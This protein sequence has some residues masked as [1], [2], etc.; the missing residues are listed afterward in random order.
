[1]NILVLG[2]ADRIPVFAQPSHKT[3]EFGVWTFQGLLYPHIELIVTMSMEHL[4]KVLSELVKP[5]YRS[6][7][8]I[9]CESATL[10]FM[11]T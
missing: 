8:D 6:E 7:V 4:S 9:F 1:M 2:G 11:D 10:F 3:V 5:T